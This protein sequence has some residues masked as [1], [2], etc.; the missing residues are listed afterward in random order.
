[1]SKVIGQYKC[2]CS[3]GPIERRDRL[4]Y[5][6]IHGADRQEEYEVP[7]SKVRKKKGKA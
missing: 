5:C 3:Y 7:K 4:T 6:S 2:G 1:M